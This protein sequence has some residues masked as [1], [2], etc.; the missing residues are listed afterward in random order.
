[1]SISYNSLSSIGAPNF[2][3]STIGEII[4]QLL[5]Y[6]FTIS[7]ILLLLFLLYGGL[8]LMLSRGDPKAVASSQGKI[9]GALTGFIIVFCAYWI[10]QIIGAVLNI[11]IIKTIFQ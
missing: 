4:V 3:G 1:M 6:V 10:V 5:P 11:T 7:G 9:T 2:A 8:T